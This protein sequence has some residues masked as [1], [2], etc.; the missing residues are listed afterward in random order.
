MS[1]RP[2]YICDGCEK[3]IG[4]KP[5][6]SLVLN[7]SQACGVAIPPGTR[8]DQ[9]TWRVSQLVPMNFAHF[10]NGKCIG[11]WADR[12]IAKAIGSRKKV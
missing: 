3:P 7:P 10:H 6:L 11:A 4:T 12:A 9:S 2:Q 8:K 5:H 1:Q